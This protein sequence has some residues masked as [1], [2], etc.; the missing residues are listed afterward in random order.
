MKFVKGIKEIVIY[1]GSG[2]LA[3]C[4]LGIIVVGFRATFSSTLELIDLNEEVYNAGNL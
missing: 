2:L 1:F 3:C 4:I